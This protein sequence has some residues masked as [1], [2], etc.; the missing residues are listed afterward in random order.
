MSARQELDAL[1]ARENADCPAT[2]LA[3]FRKPED[4]EQ[5]FAREAWDLA[6]S[7][8][9]AS[10]SAFARELVEP[11]LVGDRLSMRLDGFELGAQ[12]RVD[13]AQALVSAFGAHL[14][15]TLRLRYGDRAQPVIEALFR[16]AR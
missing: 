2:L 5:R 1:R 4:D 16:E 13:L 15:R 8:A 11:L 6:C 10:A 14:I 9:R 3:L 12:Q 7:R